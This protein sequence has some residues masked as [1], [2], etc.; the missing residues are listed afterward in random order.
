[1]GHIPKDDDFDEYMNASAEEW[2]K[3]KSSPSEPKRKE[4]STNRWGSIVQDE[5]PV[6]DNNRWGSEP[7]EPTLQEEDKAKV[8]KFFSKWWIVA[9]I[10]IILLCSCACTV[11]GGL[12]I[13]QVINIF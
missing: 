3:P 13:L 7:I 2:S 10:G 5:G 11:L 9:I 4:E 1:M 12:E 8:K 6:L